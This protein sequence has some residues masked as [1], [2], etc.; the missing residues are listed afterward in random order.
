[1]PLIKTAYGLRKIA[2]LAYGDIF[3]DGEEVFLKG[4]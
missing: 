3:P 2:N 4:Y 1:M